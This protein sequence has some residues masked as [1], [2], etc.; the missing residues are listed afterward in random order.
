[1]EMVGQ[2]LRDSC[3]PTNP[4]DVNTHQLET[5]YRQAFAGVLHS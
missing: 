2:A 3:T 1:T 4:R 5:L